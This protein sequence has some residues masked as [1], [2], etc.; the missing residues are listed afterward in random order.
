[1]DNRG[2][3]M[4]K[5]G[6]QLDPGERSALLSAQV[7]EGRYFFV[8]LRASGRRGATLAFGGRERCRA[9]YHVR[10]ERFGYHVVEFVTDGAGTLML[11]GR[12]RPLARGV[13][14]AYGPRSQLEITTDRARPLVKYFACWGGRGAGARLAR[15][16]VPAGSAAQLPAAGEVQSVFEDLSREGQWHA[17]LTRVAG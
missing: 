9:D 14:Y 10:R 15:S 12:V 1:M 7:A 8:E 2:H 17:P 5:N 11:D 4:D 13:V 3:L 6:A 16:G